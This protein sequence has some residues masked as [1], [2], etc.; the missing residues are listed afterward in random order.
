M[1][2]KFKILPVLVLGICCI[3]IDNASNLAHAW[4]EQECDEALE[5]CADGGCGEFGNGPFKNKPA[6]ETGY[7]ACTKIVK[8]N[9]MNKGCEAAH[10]VCLDKAKK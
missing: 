2:T 4:T 8:T 7:T 6:H 5:K 3:G 9:L 1:I 10:T